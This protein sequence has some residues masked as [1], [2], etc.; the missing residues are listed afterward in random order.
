M[1]VSKLM[2]FLIMAAVFTG[3]RLQGGYLDVGSNPEKIKV[4]GTQL[5]S[6]PWEGDGYR[7]K[8]WS[9]D[10]K[11][12]LLI[13][14]KD[15]FRLQNIETDQVLKF[16]PT[17]MSALNLYREKFVVDFVPETGNLIYYRENEIFEYDFS[18]YKSKTNYFG[19]KNEIN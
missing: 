5:I 9:P 7:F 17:F 19:G 16:H 2:V 8:G 4:V 6:V 15:E 14:G 1:K 18:T 10:S 11:S 12:I 3:L 13:F